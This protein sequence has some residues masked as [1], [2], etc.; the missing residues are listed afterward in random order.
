MYFNKI[1]LAR[2]VA[3][4]ALL[5][6]LLLGPPAFAADS[7][8]ATL[9]NNER[10]AQKAIAYSLIDGGHVPSNSVD[11]M[12]A[13]NEDAAQRAITNR[14]A[15]GESANFR[16]G[17]VSST[18]SEATLLHNELSAQHAIVAAPASSPF[19]DDR[20]LSVASKP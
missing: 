9:T 10:A 16:I 13:D 6:P 17:P 19:S 15:D 2:S 5:I 1:K 20:R 8:A 4:A 12:L 7:N 3:G 11:A 18:T 14:P